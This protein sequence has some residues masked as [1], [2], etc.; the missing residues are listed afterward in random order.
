V[1]DPAS[2][3]TTFVDLPMSKIVGFGEDAKGELFLLSLTSGV[4]ALLPAR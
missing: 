1:F 3:E 2:K 4:F